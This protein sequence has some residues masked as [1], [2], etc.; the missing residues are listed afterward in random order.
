MIGSPQQALH[1][2]R[3]GFLLDLDQGLEFPQTARVKVVIALFM[4]PTVEYGYQPNQF[5]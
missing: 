4:Q 1:P 3:P 2:D 5:L